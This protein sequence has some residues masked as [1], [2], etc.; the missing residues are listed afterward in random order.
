MDED[1]IVDSDLVDSLKQKNEDSGVE[2]SRLNEKINS[3]EAR[4]LHISESKDKDSSQSE[5]LLAEFEI[6]R[7][8][9]K[10]RIDQSGEE[11]YR[12]STHV[13]SLEARIL[14]ISESN[15]KDSSQS[16]ALLAEFEIERNAAKSRID[17]SGE[18]ISRLSKHVESLEARILDISESNTKDSS[19]SEALLAEF[20]I[21]RDA[22]KSRI[23]KLNSQVEEAVAVSDQNESRLHAISVEKSGLEKHVVRLE[24]DVSDLSAS[25]IQL[26]DEITSLAGQVKSN[27]SNSD[28]EERLN[29]AI[30]G[31]AQVEASVSTLETRIA[32]LL[33]E[34]ES[35]T[36]EN[37][38][39]KTVIDDADGNIVDLQFVL[40]EKKNN[41]AYLDLWKTNAE[42]EISELKSRIVDTPVD[43]AQDFDAVVVLVESF[44]DELVGR[45]NS[46]ISSD[47]FDSN[48]EAIVLSIGERSIS[49]TSL[50]NVIVKL[51]SSLVE[52]RELKIE[53]ERQIESSQS[54]IERIKLGIVLIFSDLDFN[55]TGNESISRVLELEGMIQREREEKAGLE[56]NNQAMLDRLREMKATVGPR[57][58]AEIVCFLLLLTYYLGT[59][60]RID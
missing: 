44:V 31:K 28:V 22:A 16:E 58:Q 25:N 32:D 49:L 24:K 18:E 35:M 23:D 42:L 50:Q 17:Q 21:E 59:R 5:A 11:V 60:S 20:E 30:L 37:S 48:D 39:F 4:I 13:E 29:A 54:E 26:E 52:S 7:N 15:T 56:E 51:Y 19:Q 1:P 2:I 47:D 12:L 46:L 8:A 33:S 3:L 57:L 10:S 40:E 45:L 27:A 38:H 36:V 6:E 55:S 41:I 14:D 43:S 53:L 9:A 34:C